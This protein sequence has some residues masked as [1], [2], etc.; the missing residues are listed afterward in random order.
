MWEPTWK[1]LDVLLGEGGLLETLFDQAR[2][3]EAETGRVC[4]LRAEGPVPTA[5]RCYQ[6]WNR[7]ARCRDCAV[8][9]AC[10]SGERTV[11][12]DYSDERYYL[13][14][15]QPLLWQGAEYALELVTDL[16]DRLLTQDGMARRES[17]VQ[18]LSRQL[19]A[20]SEHE[21]FT[22]LY[23][24]AYLEH[25]VQ[26]RLK[27]HDDPSLY[28]A[29]FD[30][31]DFHYINE[32]YGHVQGDAV[33]LKFSELLR[34]AL[35]GKGSCAARFDGDEFAVILAGGSE[36]EHTALLRQIQQ[37]FA[38]HLFRVAEMQFHA[39]ASVGMAEISSA[40]DFAQALE[41][42]RARRAANNRK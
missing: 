9:K 1:Q 27:H 13:L 28:L 39:S 3:I 19:E 5:Q 21:A 17:F 14:I 30:I 11:K 20:I 8:Q 18:D 32:F 33:L 26:T 12:L 38:G 41:W 29:V 22:G 37:Q 15:A 25:E 2:L 42:A 16:T 35:A 23:S 6:F 34:S 31:D 7:S 24:K 4:V 40:A 10:T 36:E